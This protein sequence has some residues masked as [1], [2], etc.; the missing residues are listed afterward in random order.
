VSLIELIWTISPALILSAIAFPSFNLLYMMDNPSLLSSNAGTIEFLLAASTSITRI[1]SLT[2]EVVPH[3]G[4]G[5]T[6]GINN[7]RLN[8][9][10][11]DITVFNNKII[12]QLVG[13]LLGDGSLLYTRTSVTPYFVFTQTIKR[14]EYIWHVY[15]TLS[16]YCG[17][18]PLYNHG[19]RKGIPYPFIQVITRSYPALIPLYKLFYQVSVNS[20]SYTKVIT[21]DLLQYLNPVS[22]AYWAMDDGS[23][24]PSGIYFHTEAFTFKEC[25]LL[26][27]MLHYRFGL[28][29]TIQKHEGKPMIKIAAKSMTLFRSIVTPHFHH[30]MLYK[31]RS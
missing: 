6:G 7:F 9:H 31:L 11:R 1:V 16:P 27:A 13:H 3:S 21:T 4:L 5:V 25:Y 30:S 22:L 15:L 28:F 24:S 23:F 10:S 20:N 18:M 14:F 2:T 12:S 17:R 26:A 29:T 8:K 19:I